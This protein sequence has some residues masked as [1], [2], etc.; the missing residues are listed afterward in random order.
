LE[1]AR[2]TPGCDNGNICGTANYACQRFT[3]N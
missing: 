2:S 3:P 1:A